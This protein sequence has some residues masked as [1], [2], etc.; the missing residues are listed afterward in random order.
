MNC[1]LIS[2]PKNGKSKTEIKHCRKRIAR[3]P[4]RDKNT[5][6]GNFE[7]DFF[8]YCQKNMFYSASLDNM[9]FAEIGRPRKKKLHPFFRVVY[10][11]ENI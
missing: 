1:L 10:T 11:Q 6:R 4:I 5:K 3:S 2:N 7:L 8:F 9:S